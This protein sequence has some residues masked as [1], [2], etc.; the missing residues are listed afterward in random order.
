ML[1]YQINCHN[2]QVFYIWIKIIILFIG[3]LPQCGYGRV[4]EAAAGAGEVVPRCAGVALY[5]RARTP[6]R[7]ARGAFLPHART[8]APPYLPSSRAHVRSTAHATRAQIL[9]PDARSS[10]HFPVRT[11]NV[12]RMSQCQCNVRRKCKFS[13]SRNKVDFGVGG[14]SWCLRFV[15]NSEEND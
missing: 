11:P 10:A 6:S 4:A 3:L 13:V 14:V 1:A 5:A 8:R 2:N 7:G 15:S 9:L 12:S